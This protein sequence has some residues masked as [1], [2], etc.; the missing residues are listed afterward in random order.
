MAKHHP[1]GDIENLRETHLERYKSGFPI[2]KELIQNAEDAES[3]VFDYGWTQGLDNAEHPLLQCPAIF[4]LDN[5]KFTYKNAKAIQ[6]IIGGSS[7]TDE[8]NAIGK[9][10]LG[11]K[12]VFHLCEAFFYVS[13]WSKI[14]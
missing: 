14:C 6:Y 2:L 8:E 1:L 11:L 12:S 13:K 4:I 9:F 10:G 5:G 3:T 7:K